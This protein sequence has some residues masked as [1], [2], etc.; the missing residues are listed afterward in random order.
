MKIR[1]AF[2][3][4]RHAHILDLLAG[5]Q[6]R[7]DCAV[8]ACC[9]QDAATRERLDVAITHTDFTAMLRDIEC[10]AIAIGDY[11]A[12]RGALAIAAL[13][14]GR[15]VLS[16]K[17]LCTS[18]DE[19]N[20][21]EELARTRGRSVFLQLDSR[22]AG[23]FR[24]LREIVRSGELGEVCTVRIDGQHPLLLGKRPAWYFEPG[25]HGGTINDIAIHAFDFV[26]W[27]TGLEW[28]SVDSARTWNAKAR[29]FPRFE[30]C[31][32]LMATLAN[33]AGVLADFS[34]LAPDRLG[35][36]LPQYWRVQIHGTRGF[37]ETH[38]QSREV[39]VVTDSSDAPDVRPA[40]EKKSRGYLE[41][42]LAEIRGGSG[43]LTTSACLRAS[44]LALVAQA[45]A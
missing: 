27:L 12:R 17:P 35:Y 44:R 11:Y 34:Y 15:H 42:F 37:A 30:D 6:G 32:Q 29:D 16:D 5:V 24:A 28:R 1:F 45:K 3:G 26:P 9:E 8:A 20:Q 31:A 39:L 18:L 25:S 19:L 41:D 10:D 40:M 7:A 2:A 43:E 4:F 38:L 33:G 14:A 36:T 23:A 21:I 13:R 22:D